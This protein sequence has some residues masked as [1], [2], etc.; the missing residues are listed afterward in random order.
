M[1]QNIMDTK[2]AAQYLAI[3]PAML[4]KLRFV[5]GGPTFCKIGRSVRYRKEALDEWIKRNEIR[6]TSEEAAHAS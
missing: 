4:I 5:G 3:S 2:N 6:S 1:E